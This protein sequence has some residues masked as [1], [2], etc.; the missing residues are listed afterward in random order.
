MLR[1]VEFDP[2]TGVKTTLDYYDDGKVV[3]NRS[4]DIEPTLRLAQYLRNEN[5]GVNKESWNHYAIIP[6]LGQVEMFRAGVNLEK[7]P[8][9]AVQW[10]NKYHPEWKV[11]NLWHDSPKAGRR[12]PKTIVK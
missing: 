5:E 11:T 10:I 3:V 1:D 9:A 7:D 8:K 12:N 4:Q 6:V 2:L